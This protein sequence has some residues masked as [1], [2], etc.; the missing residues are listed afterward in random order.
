ME[1]TGIYSEE[2]KLLIECLLSGQ[3]S[4]R[5]FMEHCKE[6]PELLDILKI[7][8]RRYERCGNVSYASEYLTMQN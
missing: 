2:S 3:M 5:Q 4:V 1:R 8:N 6:N 7:L